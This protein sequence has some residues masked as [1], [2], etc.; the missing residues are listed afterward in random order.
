MYEERPVA[1]GLIGGLAVSLTLILI[2]NEKGR[3]RRT[4]LSRRSGNGGA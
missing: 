4:A 2:S 1:A 3:P